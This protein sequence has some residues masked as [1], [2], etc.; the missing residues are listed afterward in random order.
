MHHLPNCWNAV[1]VC[2]TVM[3]LLLLLLLIVVIWLDFLER[4]I[5]KW[6]I[7]KTDNPPT[8]PFLSLHIRRNKAQ[9]GERQWGWHQQR[10]GLLLWKNIFI[11]LKT[12]G[13]CPVTREG[14]E[15]CIYFYT[16]LLNYLQN[17]YV[18]NQFC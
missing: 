1:Y 11:I 12:S 6:D 9:S 15:K 17:T 13:S 14:R 2:C 5:R 8:F 3:L 18:G 16:E 4:D 10:Q 7:H